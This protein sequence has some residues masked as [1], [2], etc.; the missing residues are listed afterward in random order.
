VKL[1]KHISEILALPAAE[2]YG[3]HAFFSITPEDRTPLEDKL[4]AVFG[5]PKDG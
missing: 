4:R 3:W 2:F 5:K 1:G